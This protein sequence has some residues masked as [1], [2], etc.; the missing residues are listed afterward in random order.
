MDSDR[1][2]AAFAVDYEGYSRLRD[3]AADLGQDVSQYV[4]MCLD[5]ANELPEGLLLA[6]AERAVDITE[7]RV[8]GR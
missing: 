6:I 4:A 8:H 2:V 7:V 1:M 5:V 3:R